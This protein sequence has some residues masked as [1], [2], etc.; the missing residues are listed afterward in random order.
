M[1][2][3]SQ[4]I[5]VPTGLGKTAAV[6]LAWLWNRVQIRNP[7]WPRRLVYCLP[8]RTLVEQTQDNLTKWVKKLVETYPENPDLQCLKKHSPIVLMGGEEV[9]DKN[10]KD[11]QR[12]WDI[13]PERPAILV[14]TQDMLLSRALNRGYAMSR[15]RWPMHFGLLNND[16]LWVMDEIQLMGVGVETSAQLDAFRQNQN[17]NRQNEWADL[18]TSTNCS[19]WWMSATVDEGQL[20]TVDHPT[21][22]NGWPTLKLEKNDLEQNNNVRKRCE[23]KK[24]LARS[25]VALGSGQ[26]KNYAC[27]LAKFVSEHHQ[28]NH[29]TL[30]IVNQVARAQE[31]FEALNEL[32]QKLKLPTCL[33]LVHSR[34]TS[35]DRKKQR[36]RLLKP[37]DRIVVATQAI[38][39]GVDVSAR[40]LITELA[41]WPALVQRFGRCNRTGEFTEGANVFWIDIEDNKKTR[42]YTAKELEVARTKLMSLNL[43]DVS[44]ASLTE[45]HEEK[46]LIIRPVLRRKDLLD[47]FDTTPDLAGRDLDI[48]RYVRDSD[49]SDV[50]V[51][52]REF[53]LDG[54]SVDTA[55]LKETGPCSVSLPCFRDFLGKFKEL[56]R[57]EDNRFVWVQNQLK[58]KW[59]QAYSARGGATYFLDHRLGGYNPQLGWTGELAD[60]K[61]S[62]NWVTLRSITAE[63][64][65]LTNFSGN[66][67]SLIGTAITLRDHTRHV[68]CKVQTLVSSLSIPSPFVEALI[69]AATWHD[70]GKA[71]PEFQNLLRSEDSAT[72]ELLAKSG[73]RRGGKLAQPRQFFRHELPSALAWLAHSKTLGVPRVEAETWCNLVAYLIAAHH[74]KVRLSLRSLPGEQ[75]PPDKVSSR[76]ARGILDDDE[77]PAVEVDGLTVPPTRLD[78][79][80]MEIGIGPAG[81]SWLARMLMLRDK[82]GPFQ[83][84]YLETLLRAADQRAS[85]A[86]A[87]QP[88]A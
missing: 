79:S 19:T 60:L 50:Q 43:K 37:I 71:F 29:L 21:P 78:L 66:E 73:Q 82:L 41:P 61:K 7:E 42:P 46:Q 86:E 65:S 80:L 18:A 88:V 36:D 64:D 16:C 44:F 6:V 23:A 76:I 51:F 14:G 47:L 28:A 63:N 81:P 53:L 70:I 17:R 31:V 1:V 30:V 75:P 58:D 15:Y 77:L 32:K 9:G 83:L 11:V 85:A 52:W 56:N 8:M 54:S 13:Y 45:V 57:T 12:A 5:N 3:H 4:I 39:A 26:K 35:E 40:V 24:K 74:G 59:E 22:I 84:A 48:S 25:D 27:D 2:C 34:F 20:D 72:T 33:V 68:V 69:A 62:Y 49:D 10:L 55:E 87:K 38:E 67:T